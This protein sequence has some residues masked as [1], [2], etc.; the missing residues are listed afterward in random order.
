MIRLRDYTKEDPDRLVSLAN[1]KNV[2]R[3]LVLTFPYPYTKADAKWWIE[4]GSKANNA[5]T[6]VIEYQGEFVGSVGILPQTGWRS[7]IA[8]IGY[9]IGE[10]Y[11]GKGLATW[12]LRAMTDDAFKIPAMQKLYAPVMGPNIASKRV[13]EKC[14]YGLEAVLKQ[15]VF[16]E[17]RYYDI[18][19]YALHRP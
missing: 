12:A 8:E 9:W 18:Y 19:Q 1:N 15:E 11:W 17:G 13:L 7:H 3:Y 2:S 14:G 5:I 10:G 16:K 6:K 4:T